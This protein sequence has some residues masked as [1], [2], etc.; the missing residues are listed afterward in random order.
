MNFSAG[1]NK[2]RIICALSAL[3]HRSPRG[4]FLKSSESC[5]HRMKAPRVSPVTEGA[6]TAYK[7]ENATELPWESERTVGWHSHRG[8]TEWLRLTQCGSRE[9]V[10]QQVVCLTSSDLLHAA[11]CWA[12]HPECSSATFPL[13]V[14]SS[15]A[16]WRRLMWHK[17]CWKIPGWARGMPASVK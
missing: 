1:F 3:P 16:F 2:A 10:L 9:L 12:P 17:A 6:S 11:G 14:H 15:A 8:V 13:S 4:L 5:Q 7:C